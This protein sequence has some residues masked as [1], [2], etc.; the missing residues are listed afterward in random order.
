MIF[1]KLKT[2]HATTIVQFKSNDTSSG[3]IDFDGETDEVTI[4]YENASTIIFCGI[5]ATT[6][7]TPAI[8]RSAAAKGVQTVQKL[9]RKT[10]AFVIPTFLL[11]NEE[12]DKAVIDG[13]ILGAYK[14]NK[15]KSEKTFTVATIELISCS[16]TPSAIQKLQF[17]DDAVNYSRDL[18]N[19]NASVITPQQLAAEACKLKNKPGIS[20]TVLDAPALIRHKLNLINAVGCGSSTPPVLIILEYTGSKQSKKTT[21][22]VGK[23]VTFDSGG[24]NLKPTGSIETMR[25]DMAG[26]SAVLGIFSAIEKMRP[27]IN[28]IGVIPAVH[29]AIGS[30]AFFPGDIYTSY[31]GKTVEIWSTDAEGRLILADAVAYCIKKYKPGC[32]IDLATLTGGILTA[33]GEYVAGLFSNDSDLAA[34]LFSAGEETGERLWQFPIYKEY[35]DSLKGDSGDLRNLSKFKKGY[36]SSIIGA[37]FIKEFVGDTSW[38]HIDIAGTAFNE[39][40]ARGIT[41]QYGTGFGVRLLLSFLGL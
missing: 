33:L 37:A 29:N 21:A 39:G 23:G 35:S 26:A 11:G 10:A 38:A 24:L 7:C 36:A 40:S 22:I 14:F 16:M 4:R 9:K 25:Q 5:G 15:Y 13:I 18:I 1:K 12:I 6:S 8:I 2:P 19:E 34:R 32:I 3:I 30:K 27:A 41:P 17:I 28:L 20:V 31:L